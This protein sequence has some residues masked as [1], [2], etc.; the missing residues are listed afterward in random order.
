MGLV[1]AGVSYTTGEISA[2]MPDTGGFIRHATRFVDPA[3]GAA[4]GWNFW[5]TMAISV[6]AEISAAAT[7]VQFWNA[8]INPAVWITVFLVFIVVVNFCGVRL[9]GEVGDGE[10]TASANPVLAKCIGPVNIPF[11]PKSY[12]LR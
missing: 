7:V 4:T 6:P 10:Y 1:T 12:S 5:Y 3:L 2:F 9:Y 8:T 11:S